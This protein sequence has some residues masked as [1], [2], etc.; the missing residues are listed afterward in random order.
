M[1]SYSVIEVE[2]GDWKILLRELTDKDIA[3]SKVKIENDKL[4]FCVS[5]KNEEVVFAKLKE[6]CY[7]YKIIEKNGLSYNLKKFKKRLGL[8]IGSAV[9]F[10]LCFLL[11]NTLIKVELQGE[12]ANY[13]EEVYS[14]LDGMNIKCGML[15][16]GI[17]ENELEKKLSTIDGISFGEAKLVGSVLYLGG[18]KEL[19]KPNIY[20][21]VEGK[22]IV[23][24]FDG[25]IT[26]IAVESGT[27]LVQ[28]GQTVKAGDILIAPYECLSQDIEEQ[29]PCEAKGQVYAKAYLSEN[30]FF[31][32][33]RMVNERTG[34]KKSYTS[35]EFFGK[36]INEIKES[37]FAIYEKEVS[38]VQSK[39]II[40]F[41][42]ITVTYYET[43]S[44]VKTVSIEDVYDEIVNN[45]TEKLNKKLN[46]GTLLKKWEIIKKSGANYIIDVFYEAEML[47]NKR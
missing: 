6:L 28:V 24:N 36:A 1:K 31:I 46:G 2:C 17:D 3:V 38:V 30:I 23:A 18:Q 11:C 27:A 41:N 29:T 43:Q 44:A 32:P 8:V 34:Q 47:I 13:A 19:P 9:A 7:N 15:T 12:A 25:I 42:I 5:E 26:R 21:P 35:I 20:E 39:S 45:A 37:P 33:E 4:R 16:F 40:P 10:C 22:P 14:V